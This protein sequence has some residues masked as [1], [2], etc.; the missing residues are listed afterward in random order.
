MRL[1]SYRANAAWRAGIVVGECVADLERAGRANGWKLPATVR[2]LLETDKNLSAAKR[3]E[4]QLMH[5]ARKPRWLM[6]VSD[7][8]LGPPI[9]DP[10]KIIALGFNYRSHADEQTAFFRKPIEP[11]KT[12]VIFA[13]YASA[14]VG[15][16]A[17]IVLPPQDLTKEVDY[18]VEL[19]AVI[20]RAAR[21][22]SEADALKYVAGYMVM[23]DVSAR[24]CQFGDRQWT[25]A[26]SFDTFAPCG[27]WLVTPD[28]IK[29]WPLRLWTKLNGETVQGST[30][31]DMI[32]SAAHVIAYLSRGMT[33]VPGDLI[34][35]GTPAGVG[36]FRI[37]ERMLRDGDVVACG[38]EGIGE[39]VNEVRSER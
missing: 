21:G 30:T 34:A 26:K 10:Q 33:L 19:V 20:G 32:F 25:R 37:P 13:K 15:P 23:N 18:E 4:K 11:P 31:G 24:D 36:K 2:E 1:V 35:T 7:L 12:P 8:E 28:G 39:L 27:P 22:V 6:H 16:R 14:L 9:P 5:A 17:A 3:V 38:V 29:E